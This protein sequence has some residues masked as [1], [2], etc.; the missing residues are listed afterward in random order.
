[1]CNTIK[2]YQFYIEIFCNLFNSLKKLNFRPNVGPLYYILSSVLI[3]IDCV[4]TKL[5]LTKLSVLHECFI[6]EYKIGSRLMI[7]IRDL[8][9]NVLSL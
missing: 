4:M 6:P 9:W 2:D 7:C 1:M 5:T 8:I 3:Q